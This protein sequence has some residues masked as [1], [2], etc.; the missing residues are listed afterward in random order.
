MLQCFYDYFI[1]NGK[2]Q[3]CSDFDSDI[4]SKG[5]SIYEVFRLIDG[6]PLFYNEHIKRLYSSARIL[7]FDIWYTEKQIWQEVNKLI[8]INK[9]KKGNIEIIFN[10]RNNPMKTFLALFIENRYPSEEQYH[11]GL[12]SMLFPAVRPTPNAKQVILNLRE[13]TVKKIRENGLYDVVLV[14]EKGYVTEG[15]RSNVFFIMNER[16]FTP[17][18]HQILPGITRDKVF[19]ICHKNNISIEETEI[20]AEQI[21]TFEA[22][23]FSGTS[24]KILP[25]SM[26]GNFI[27]DVR[28]Q[29]LLRLMDFYNQCIEEYINSFKNIA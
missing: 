3:P 23:F 7:K 22:M 6:I 10:C 13:D 27:F 24:P 4:F 12:P 15:S 26:I 29:T 9:V 18:I 25:V 19:E 5:Q 8:Q 11:S 17:P 28:N 1:L 14:D 21:N 16:I 2:V 20:K